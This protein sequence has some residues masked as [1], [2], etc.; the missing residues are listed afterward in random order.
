[1]KYSNQ[2]NILLAV[3]GCIVVIWVFSQT[4]LHTGR[5]PQLDLVEITPA[6]TPSTQVPAV[7]ESDGTTGTKPV[8]F[9][10]PS[11]RNLTDHTASESGVSGGSM[12]SQ[13]RPRPSGNTPAS[14]TAP[15]ISVSRALQSN[16][17]EGFPAPAQA[18]QQDAAGTESGTSGQDAPSNVGILT[19][20]SRTGAGNGAGQENPVR[21]QLRS[22][23]RPLPF[24]H[25]R[26]AQLASNPVPGPGN[27][28]PGGRPR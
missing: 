27:S 3:S 5:E 24:F 4:Y 22:Q 28:R 2:I 9:G 26:Q 19:A 13:P 1:M 16:P 14:R 10:A 8:S 21:Q 18:D 6:T 12:A 7:Y 25:G 17:G 11:R 15:G 20:S 23:I